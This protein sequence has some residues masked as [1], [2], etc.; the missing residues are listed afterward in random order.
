M[1]IK[2]FGSLTNLETQH[3]KMSYNIN[4][5]KDAWRLIALKIHPPNFSKKDWNS[6]SRLCS[7]TSEIAKELKLLKMKSFQVNL[8]A[9]EKQRLERDAIERISE[10]QN[11]LNKK[12]VLKQQKIGNNIGMIK[13]REIL[14]VIKRN[15]SFCRFH[16]FIKDE[17]IWR[18]TINNVLVDSLKMLNDNNRQL[19]LIIRHHPDSATDDGRT[20][21]TSFLLQN[22]VGFDHESYVNNS[23]FH[24]KTICYSKYT[25]FD[26]DD[27]VLIFHYGRACNEKWFLNVIFC[28]KIAFQKEKLNQIIENT[29]KDKKT[30]IYFSSELE[31]VLYDFIRDN[32]VISSLVQFKLRAWIKIRGH[33]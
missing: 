30:D 28:N 5:T 19:N 15:H 9:F 17:A 10:I 31:L 13:K 7:R 11:Q 16:F 22:V 23:F 18:Q 3:Q 27:M 14:N 1:K 33:K 4:L 6:F 2:Q 24:V 21:V 25:S 8:L 26:Q 29:K 20:I 12:W 32:P